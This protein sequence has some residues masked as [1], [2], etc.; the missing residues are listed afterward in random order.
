MKHPI[1]EVLDIAGYTQMEA[2]RL[3]GISQP[4]LSYR[5]RNEIEG[6]IGQ[7]IEMAK[8]LRVTQYEIVT[9]TYSL[10]V[11]IKL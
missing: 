11:K 9:P 1:K 2:S 8:L 5:M 10:K 7:S 3:T 6:S 4:L